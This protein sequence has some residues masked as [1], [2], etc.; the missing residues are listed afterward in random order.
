MRD[1]YSPSDVPSNSSARASSS[2]LGA[3]RPKRIISR[4]IFKNFALNM[5]FFC[6]KTPRKPS[7]PHS[8]FVVLNAK[9]ISLDSLSTPSAPNSPTKCGYVV[10]L[11]T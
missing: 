6:A 7:D 5:F 1:K 3:S 4:I 9:D 11:N 2:T 8:T 10:R